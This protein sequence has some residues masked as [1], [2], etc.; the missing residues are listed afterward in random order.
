MRFTVIFSEKFLYAKKNRKGCWIK[1]KATP[2]QIKAL[3]LKTPETCRTE[4]Y[5]LD[6]LRNTAVNM[7][8]PAAASRSETYALD[9][10][11]NTAVN[12][13]VSNCNDYE[14]CFWKETSRNLTISRLETVGRR[15]YIAPQATMGSKKCS[16]EQI[17]WTKQGKM[18]PY[19]INNEYMLGPEL[20]VSFAKHV[21]LEP[22]WEKHGVPRSKS[23]DHFMELVLVGL[24]KNPIC[25]RRRSRI[26]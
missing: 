14:N 5:L 15:C 3:P 21:F 1:E 22:E 18:W 11:R 16:E 4:A 23:V 10:L 26:T 7:L 24:S 17:E 9:C 2:T 6:R 8:L 13:L 19:P 12:M 20:K 25:Q